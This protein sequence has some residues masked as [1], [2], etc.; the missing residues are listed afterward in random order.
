MTP[1]DEQKKL[2]QQKH[3]EGLR[4]RLMAKKGATARPDTP[5]KAPVNSEAPPSQQ[6][7][8]QKENDTAINRMNEPLSDDFG[9]ESLLAEGKAAA[10]KKVALDQEAAQRALEAAMQTPANIKQQQ[11]AAQ[12]HS[13]MELD[14]VKTAVAQ[15]KLAEP[16]QP[17]IPSPPKSADTQANNTTLTPNT[18]SVNMSDPYYD[19]LAVWLEFTG[20]HDVQFRNSK[21]STYKE[22]RELEQEAAR[23]AEKLEKLK[24]AEKADLESLRATT[25][26]PS[27]ATPM[28]PPPLPPIMPAGDVRANKNNLKRAHSPE[29]QTREKAGRRVSDTGFRFRGANDS[30]A[31]QPRAN[32]SPLQRRE[33]L[34]ERRKSLEDRDP[35]LERRQNNYGG[36]RDGF[37]PRANG[38]GGHNQWGSSRDGGPPPFNA[39]RERERESRLGFSS[40][41]RMGGPQARGND[42]NLDLRKGGQS[43]SRR[44]D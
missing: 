12:A 42:S 1:S 24:Q 17:H 13:I 27:V 23:I 11:A 16:A 6:N 30:G 34:P 37:P 26:H 9:I 35:S 41:N 4:K 43:T 29:P 25:A 3:I 31:A 32:G 14:E 2:E 44:Y 21:L 19:D 7:M 40:V 39:N 18:H 10:E 5:S 33:S 38:R 20:Y 28:A 15:A 36:N 22:R 8:E